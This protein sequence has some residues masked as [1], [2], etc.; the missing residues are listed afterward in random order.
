MSSKRK[1]ALLTVLLLTACHNPHNTV[2]PTDAAEFDQATEAQL[3]KLTPDE[4]ALVE[5]YATRHLGGAFGDP[6]PEGTTF[7]KAIEDQKT[8]EA[9]Q[10]KK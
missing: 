1:S 4:R 9:K 5:R 7:A 10:G 6:I 2:L 8:F 3:Q